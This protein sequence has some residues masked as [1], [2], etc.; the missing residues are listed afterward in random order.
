MK[1]EHIP[2]FEPYKFIDALAIKD[3]I[4][5]LS[6]GN[7]ILMKDSEILRQFDFDEGTYVLRDERYL[8]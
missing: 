3:H 5:V 2:C 7:L 1:Y 4:L 6:S 8:A